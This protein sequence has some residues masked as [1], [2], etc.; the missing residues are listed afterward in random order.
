MIHSKI[1]F[2]TA[3][4]R[5]SPDFIIVGEA[6]CGTTSLYRYLNQLPSIL[7]SD[8]KEPN[9]FI[10]FG[11]SPLFCKIHYPSLPVYHFKKW[12]LGTVKAGEASAEYFSKPK[13]PEI[14]HT[15]LPGVKIIC[16]FRDPVKRAYS[17]WQMLTHAKREHRSFSEVVEHS[18]QFF[19]RPDHEL[20]LSA[21]DHLE[22]HPLRY[23][24]RGLYIRPLRRWQQQFPQDQILCLTSE[25]LFK[26]PAETLQTTCKFLGMDCDP[27][28]LIFEPRKKGRYQES[29][30]AELENTL[31][32]FY[33]PWNQLLENET[34]LKTTW[35]TTANE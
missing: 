2:L 30:P 11:G 24:A 16:L 1:R 27:E 15:L 20:L 17:D 9:N 10:E 21:L 7:G 13:L 25:A 33:R 31:R 23:V 32:T 14:I 34:G 26:T 28:T 3:P 6:K 22:Y 8:V 35:E 4:F 29:C 12:R 18:L 19:D 5:I